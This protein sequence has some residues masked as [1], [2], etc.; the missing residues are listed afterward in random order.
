MA[1]ICAM[2]GF[3]IMNTTKKHLRRLLC[4]LLS[5]LLLSSLAVAAFAAK[6][7]TKNEVPVIF[8]AG[9]MSTKTIDQATGET[10]FPPSK[11]RITAAAQA[12]VETAAKR[13]YS[14]REL[15]WKYPLNQAALRLFDGIRCD[16][17]GVQTLYAHMSAF[18]VSEGDKVNVGDVIGYVGS[19]G[20]D[21]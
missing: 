11:E 15:N 1:L 20:K 5:L 12:L 8:V 4:A 18:N 21:P 7:K 13:L 14:N 6:P 17:N 19:T 10:L 3:D 2:R 9:F 16:E